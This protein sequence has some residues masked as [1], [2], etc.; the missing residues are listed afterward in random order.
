MASNDVTM[1]EEEERLLAEGPAQ[2][3][4]LRN[5][6]PGNDDRQRAIDR[7]RKRERRREVSGQQE[8]DEERELRRGERRQREEEEQ[9]EEERKRKEE[10]KRKCLEKPG[11]S[12]CHKCGK[13]GHYT[14][15]AELPA[16]L[17]TEISKWCIIFKGS[18]SC[19]LTSSK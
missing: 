2:P 17:D 3:E 14:R 18:A 13:I 11:K 15:E 19:L 16:P 9:T 6:E 1:A 8:D 5:E 10:A 4:E 12:K 7:E